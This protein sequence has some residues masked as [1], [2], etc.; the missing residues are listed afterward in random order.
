MTRFAASSIGSNH[1]I[2]NIPHAT[3]II[4]KTCIHFV[5]QKVSKSKMATAKPNVLREANTPK[6]PAPI[7][8]RMASENPHRGALSH[9]EL[10][11]T[12]WFI[13]LLLER[14]RTIGW[15]R[16]PCERAPHVQLPDGRAPA[17]HPQARKRKLPL[18]IS[19]VVRQRC[20]QHQRTA[21]TPPIGIGVAVPAYA[22]HYPSAAFAMA[23]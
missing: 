7:N 2:P 12:L 10:G 11:F 4:Q 15:A 19:G 6:N 23:H 1:T 20:F 14:L 22:T 16:H 3:G 8:L 9:S 17:H 18:M 5:P 21:M 13:A